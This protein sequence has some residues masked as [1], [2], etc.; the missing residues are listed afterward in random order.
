VPT[1]TPIPE[2]LAITVQAQ[3]QS[4]MLSSLPWQVENQV[5]ES[6]AY[7]VNFTVSPW[8]Q[9][10]EV[11]FYFTEYTVPEGG[12]PLQLTTGAGECG[13]PGYGFATGPTGHPRT[14]TVC[15]WAGTI[16]PTSAPQP[17]E[18]P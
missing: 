1:P 15:L 3:T 10:T 5:N 2:T 17:G 12:G 16:L 18:C 7:S 11:C 13:D 6:T 9:P 4:L 14:Y 8:P